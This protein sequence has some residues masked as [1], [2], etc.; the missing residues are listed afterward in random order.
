VNIWN[1]GTAG[2]GLIDTS[3]IL[4]LALGLA[5]CD[6]DCDLFT[7][8]CIRS[9]KNF[10]RNAIINSVYPTDEKALLR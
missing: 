9:D 8:S 5:A 6:P 4:E 1:T 2:E 7:T 3:I 10:S